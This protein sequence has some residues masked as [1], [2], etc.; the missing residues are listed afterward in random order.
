M[1]SM[2]TRS[3]NPIWTMVPDMILPKFLLSPII[4][5]SYFYS[6]DDELR[7]RAPQL[8]HINLPA[9]KC[10][11]IPQQPARTIHERWGRAPQIVAIRRQVPYPIPNAVII[12]R[13]ISAN[14]NSFSR[15]PDAAPV[16]RK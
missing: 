16:S 2:V 10:A 13:G 14:G 6:I 8:N 7:P 1:K 5:F 12:R 15:G 9:R 3:G 4:P 11:S